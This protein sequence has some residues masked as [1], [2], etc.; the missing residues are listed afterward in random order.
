MFNPLV[1]SFD[2]IWYDLECC[3]NDPECP[4]NC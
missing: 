3:E 2:N 1:D 4:Y